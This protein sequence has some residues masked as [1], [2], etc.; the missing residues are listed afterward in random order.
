MGRKR[1]RLRGEWIPT[2]SDRDSCP[3]LGLIKLPLLALI[4]WE[5]E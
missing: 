2:D 4:Q 5:E 1:Q 3:A